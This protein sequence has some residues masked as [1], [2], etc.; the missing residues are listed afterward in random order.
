[1]PLTL[2]TRYIVA[3]E[4]I[5]YMHQR[6]P[7]G[8]RYYEMVFNPELL[9]LAS[10][11]TGIYRGDHKLLIGSSGACRVTTTSIAKSIPVSEIL[12]K[13]LLELV[14]YGTMTEARKAFPGSAYLRELVTKNH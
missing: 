11:Q 9:K 3:L 5:G 13:P 12:T 14:Q 4:S 7:R 1:M 8:G 2:K 6:N 10:P